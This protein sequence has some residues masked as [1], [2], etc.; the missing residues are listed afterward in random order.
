MATCD[1]VGIRE[2]GLV[3]ERHYLGH[4]ERLCGGDRTLRD[5]R[6]VAWAGMSHGQSAEAGRMATWLLRSETWLQSRS[7]CLGCEWLC[8]SCS[9]I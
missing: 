7:L 3:E 5:D 1:L 6:M 9:R 4:G 2:V 8:F